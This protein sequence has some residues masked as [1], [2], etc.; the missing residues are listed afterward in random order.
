MIS[1]DIHSTVNICKH[2]TVEYR[3]IDA[4]RLQARYLRQLPTAKAGWPKHCVVQYIR[5]ALVE[6]ENVTLRDESLNE[7]TKLTLQG[8]VDKILKRK[9]QLGGLKD[10]FHYQNK[11]CPRL[12]LIMGGPG[13]YYKVLVVVM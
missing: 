10:I 7:I 9:A 2:P 11:P 8:E 12:I 4:S 6:K 1:T 3:P 13:E 5:L